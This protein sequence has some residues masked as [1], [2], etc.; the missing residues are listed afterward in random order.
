MTIGDTI[1]YSVERRLRQKVVYAIHD[2]IY[3][4]L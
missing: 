4:S 1:V 3:G 2:R